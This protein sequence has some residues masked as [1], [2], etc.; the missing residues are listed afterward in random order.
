MVER[1]Q[2]EREKERIGSLYVLLCTP[3]TW[4]G[5]HGQWRRAEDFFFP[6]LFSLFSLRGVD[7]AAGWRGATSACLSFDKRLHSRSRPTS[8]GVFATRG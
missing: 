2:G 1:E 7:D 8:T 4:P 6:F 5:E 3:K